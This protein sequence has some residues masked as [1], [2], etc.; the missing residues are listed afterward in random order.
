MP[1]IRAGRGKRI[2][3]IT[4]KKNITKIKD[5]FLQ[6]ICSQN[7]HIVDKTTIYTMKSLVVQ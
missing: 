4:F 1:Q 3:I 7:R 5:Y 6:C 2:C